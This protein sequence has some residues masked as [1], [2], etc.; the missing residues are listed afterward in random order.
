MPRKIIKS[1]DSELLPQITAIAGSRA[2]YGYRRMTACLNRERR[3]LGLPPLNH[4]RIYRIMRQNHLLLAPFGRRPAKVH[5]GAELQ[6][7]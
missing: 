3:N 1:T 6:T 2:T 4:K 5:D 7:I